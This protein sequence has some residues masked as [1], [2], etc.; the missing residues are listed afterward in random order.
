MRMILFFDLPSITKKDNREYVKFVKKIKKLGF[1]MMQES[2]YTKLAINP[3][4]VAACMAEL[5]KYL[6]PE[7]I[8]SVLNITEKHFSSIEN[9]IGEIKTDVI[10]SEDKVIKL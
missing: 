9:L 3:N 6:P 2:V 8:V 7:G 10:N 5:K 1:V 4:A